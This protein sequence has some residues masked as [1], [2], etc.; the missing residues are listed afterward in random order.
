MNRIDDASNAALQRL[1][2]R[3][4]EQAFEDELA[5]KINRYIHERFTLRTAPTPASQR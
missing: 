4:G 2:T 5:S 1:R 3:F